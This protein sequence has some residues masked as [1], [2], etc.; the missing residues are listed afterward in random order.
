M[1]ALRND[2]SA[3]NHLDLGRATEGNNL[4]IKGA[5]N[6]HRSKE[7]EHKAVFDTCRDLERQGFDVTFLDMDR[8][9]LIDL[10]A[11][12]AVLRPETIA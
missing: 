3:R 2:G 11:L 10:D 4:A 6:F 12:R 5:A 9:T 8:R 1:A 7:A